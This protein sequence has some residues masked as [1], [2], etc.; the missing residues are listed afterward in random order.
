[1]NKISLLSIIVVL[2]VSACGSSIINTDPALL[3]KFSELQSKHDYFKMKKLFVS[4]EKELSSD[5]LLYYGA[6]IDSYFSRPEES[7]EKIEDLLEQKKCS[8]SD[9]L[10]SVLLSVKETNHARLFEYNEAAKTC[11]LL[12]DNFEVF[13]SKEEYLELTN[14][15]YFWKALKN[16]PKQELRI[17]GRPEMSFD[18]DN[19]GFWNFNVQLADT[20]CHFIF[21]T[22]AGTSMIKRSVAIKEGYKII[23]LEYPVKAFTGK[24][25]ETNLAIAEKIKIGDLTF[26]HVIFLVVD[27]KNLNIPNKNISIGGIIGLPVISALEEI[28]IRHGKIIIPQDPLPKTEEN[29]VI[30]NLAPVVYSGYQSDSIFMKFD[31]GALRTNFHSLFYNNY[32]KQIETNCKKK[33]VRAGSV[34]GPVEFDVFKTGELE[35]E[36]GKAKA[37]IKNVNI[38]TEEI[39]SAN[40]YLHGN[41]GLDYINQ[42]NEINISFLNS[43]ITFR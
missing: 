4:H 6:I 29:L 39:K 5:Y 28:S 25:I 38:F 33:A 22:G 36:V 41:L 20:T 26:D 21:D 9:S 34:G 14:A 15:Y 27:D 2:L 42:F 13:F 23:E 40:R 3:M 43:T 7:N 8:V 11:K 17:Y 12:M 30:Q 32:K 24:E 31:T 16:I 37:K 10:M 19:R 18:T 35:L 1:M